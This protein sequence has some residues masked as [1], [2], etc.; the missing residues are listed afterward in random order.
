[1]GGDPRFLRFLIGIG[2]RQL[3]L[4]VRRIPKAQRVIEEITATEAAAFADQALQSRTA[5]EAATHFGLP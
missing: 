4:D 3:S 2:L 1:M 5:R